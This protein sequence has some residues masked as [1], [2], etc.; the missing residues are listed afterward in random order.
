[1]KEE[2]FS[3]MTRSKSAKKIIKVESLTPIKK[4]INPSEQNKDYNYELGSNA[5]LRLLSTPSHSSATSRNHIHI[6]DEMT[7]KA[8][9]VK[10]KMYVPTNLHKSN[11]SLG[12]TEK[13]L[14][15]RKNLH[16]YLNHKIVDERKEINSNKLRRLIPQHP[17]SNFVVLNNSPINNYKMKDYMKLNIATKEFLNQKMK[18]IKS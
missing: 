18:N 7:F 16:N 4:N 17:Q 10:N 9:S 13:I 1:M 5:K 14:E 12:G 11:K 3:N 15:I 2:V 8:D 6:K